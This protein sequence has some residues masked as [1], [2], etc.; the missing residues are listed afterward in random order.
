[1]RITVLLA[2]SAGMVRSAALDMEAMGA[3]PGTVRKVRR[4]S[5]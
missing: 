4:T 2:D 1:M 5:I 3:E